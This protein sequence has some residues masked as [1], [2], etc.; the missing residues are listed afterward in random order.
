MILCGG[1]T[2]VS[3]VADEAYFLPL[4]DGAFRATAHTSGPWDP[5]LQH[6]GPPSA[7]LARAIEQVEHTWPSVLTRVSVDILGPI[8]V[9]DLQLDARVVRPGRSVELVVAE[10]ASRGRPV[11]RASGWRLRRE[12]TGLPDSAVPPAPPMPG[13]VGDDLGWDCG[14]LRSIDWHWVTGH[15]LEPGPATV[16]T[17]MRVPLVPGEEPTGLQRTLVVA[18]SANGIS[19]MLHVQDWYFINADLT[20]HLLRE[21][22]GE[23][24]C[25]QAET[26]VT[27]QGFGLAA[28]MLYDADGA[29]A[30]G[31]QTLRVAPRTNGQ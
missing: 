16:W 9:G 31:A 12:E 19:N 28:S 18:D 3:S 20:V 24:I 13:P 14:Y 2:N 6:G 27:G 10:L 26:H 25:L 21:P 8:P 22:Q 29:V 30:R 23:W 7:L 17:R 4:G 15:F 5:A 1:R 11:A